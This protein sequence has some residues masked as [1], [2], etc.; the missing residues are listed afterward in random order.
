MRH[1]SVVDSRAVAVSGRIHR[2][3]GVQYDLTAISGWSRPQKAAIGLYEVERQPVPEQIRLTGWRL[4]PVGDVVLE[5]PE[6]AAI[7]PEEQLAEE[8]SAMVVSRFQAR[9]A[10]LQ[11]GLL[12]AV[13]AAMPEADPI[14][15]LAWDEAVEF[16]RLSPTIATLAASLGLSDTDLDALFRAARGI[17]A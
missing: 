12:P 9:A 4:E 2:H 16:R 13:E 7:T 5:I 15:R 8:R 3:A 1:A 10:L 11:A 6:G 14:A 17:E